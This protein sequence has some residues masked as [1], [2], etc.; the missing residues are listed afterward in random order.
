M[1]PEL[2]EKQLKVELRKRMGEKDV[3]MH[4]ELEREEAVR[5]PFKGEAGRSGFTIPWESVGKVEDEGEGVGTVVSL[6]SGQCL[7]V[8]LG[9]TMHVMPEGLRFE[10]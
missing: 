6:T 4:M 5:A 1:V 7:Y 9:V 3:E 8:H 2:N 10:V